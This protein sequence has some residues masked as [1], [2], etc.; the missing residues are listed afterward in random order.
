MRQLGYARGGK[1]ETGAEAE[2][3]TGAEIGIGTDK[4]TNNNIN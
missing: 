3:Q 4:I 2:T 1:T